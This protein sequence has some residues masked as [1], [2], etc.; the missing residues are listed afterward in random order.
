MHT[1]MYMHVHMEGIPTHSCDGLEGE[2]KD[3]HLLLL[4]GESRGEGRVGGACRGGVG[5][6]HACHPAADDAAEVGAEGLLHCLHHALQG[7][8]G[9]VSDTVV[10]ILKPTKHQDIV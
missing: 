8:V 3:L 7:P 9:V 10:V 5:V 6:A 2:L 1:C 4:A